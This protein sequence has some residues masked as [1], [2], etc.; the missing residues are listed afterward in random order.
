MLHPDRVGHGE[1]VE[2]ELRAGKGEFQRF[3]GLNE[4][5]RVV[6][7][8]AGDGLGVVGGAHVGGV[9]LIVGKYPAVAA[10]EV[11]VGVVGDVPADLFNVACLNLLGHNVTLLFR[12]Q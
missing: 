7:L 12:V 9:D 11:D 6:A 3:V 5:Q 10:L 1:H 4:R 2:G 8:T